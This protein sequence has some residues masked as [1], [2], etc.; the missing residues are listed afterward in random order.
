MRG[1]DRGLFAAD[2]A[3]ETPRLLAAARLILLNEAEAWDVVQTTA[4][5]AIRRGADLRD[6]AALHSWLGVILTREAFRLRRRARRALSFENVHTELPSSP[7]PGV[8]RILVRDALARLPARIRTAV[9]LHHMLGLSI[10]E[11][12]RAMSV[13]ENTSR[14][15]VRVGIAQLREILSDE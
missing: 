15:Q 6:P 12:A 13:S 4:E 11:V 2:V 14:S 3:A 7:G 5:I 1:L 8:D 9:V 10:A